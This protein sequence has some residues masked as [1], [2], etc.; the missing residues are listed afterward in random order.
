MN[1]KTLCSWLVL[2][3]AVLIAPMS[4]A[5]TVISPDMQQFLSHHGVSMYEDRGRVLLV[6]Y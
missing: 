4:M 5:N 2:M 6:M 3:W 1:K